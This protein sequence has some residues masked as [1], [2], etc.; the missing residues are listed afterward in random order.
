LQALAQTLVDTTPILPLNARAGIVLGQMLANPAS[1]DRLPSR[2]PKPGVPGS[3][4]A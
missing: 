1:C 4:A 3:V 2:Q